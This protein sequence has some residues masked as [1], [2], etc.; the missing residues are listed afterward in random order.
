ME[1][2]LIT[3]G[4]G[5]I[6]SSLSAK[7]LKKGYKVS[8][9]SR[10]QSQGNSIRSYQW[11]Y[12]SNY[13]DAEAIK[14]ADFIIHLAGESLVKKRWTKQQK[15]LIVDSRVKTTELLFNEVTSNNKKL[16]A[17]ISASGVGYYGA[18]NSEK[19]AS[20]KDNYHNDF[21]GL[22]CLEWEQSAFQFQDKGIRTVVLRTGM[23][24]SKKGGALSKLKPSFKL[25]FGSAMG[26]G[27][28][29]VS[30]IHID[31]LCEMYIKAIEDQR[32]KGVYNAVAPEQITNQ[33]FS[34]SVAKS[35]D[36][37]FWMPNVPSFVLKLML[38]EMSVM[39]L[40]GIRISSKKIENVGFKFKF[41][42]LGQALQN[43]IKE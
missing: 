31:D 11:D 38:G 9:L 35:L 33:D 6:G 10:F 29:Y 25:G 3:G 20:E 16:K 36:K 24:L 5:L 15:Q 23:V 8:H 18:I 21:L 12:K 30:W 34:R 37:L 32:M 28:Q 2:V 40:K 43:L 4:S 26:T 27:K 1:S 19:I 17:F 14:D 7:L 13:I 41:P 42:T 39:L 22:V